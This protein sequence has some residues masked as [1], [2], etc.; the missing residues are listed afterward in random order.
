MFYVPVLKFTLHY[1]IST[2]EILIY[3]LIL[4]TF[5]LPVRCSRPSL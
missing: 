3:R 4:F 2:V 5:V 1:R